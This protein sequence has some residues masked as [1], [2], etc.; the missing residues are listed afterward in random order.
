M[1]PAPQHNK[2]V[3][4]ALSQN[5]ASPRTLHPYIWSCSIF[6]G[7]TLLSVLWI[8]SSDR[9]LEAFVDDPGLLVRMGMYKG[10]G[11]VGVTGLLLFLLVR[12]AFTN[13]DHN[14][15]A[16][17]VQEQEIERLNRLYFGS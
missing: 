15:R 2:D 8:Y 11:F 10:L 4:L 9:A 5:K 6:F 17:R 13:M 12:W 14:Y 7:Y 1:H 3:K 16:V